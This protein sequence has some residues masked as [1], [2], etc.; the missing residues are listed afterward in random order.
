MTTIVYLGQSLAGWSLSST[1][2]ITVDSLSEIKIL[3]LDKVISQLQHF[4][5]G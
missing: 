4:G 5:S 2:D 3:R 1:Y